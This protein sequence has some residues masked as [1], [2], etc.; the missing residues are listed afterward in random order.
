M[1]EFKRGSNSWTRSFA[2]I[3]QPLKVKIRQSRRCCY[4]KCCPHLAE[5]TFAAL[6]ERRWT[7]HT[8]RRTLNPNYAKTYHQRA[9]SPRIDKGP[10]QITADHTHTWSSHWREDFNWEN[11]QEATS[12]TRRKV[13]GPARPFSE[14]AALRVNCRRRTVWSPAGAPYDMPF[15]SIPF[16]VQPCIAIHPRVRQRLRSSCALFSCTFA[17]TFASIMHWSKVF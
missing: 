15:H 17:A 11:I 1:L 14:W 8:N 9:E 5:G 7:S 13:K 6:F 4:T 10:D 12:A 2:H 3:E 16:Q